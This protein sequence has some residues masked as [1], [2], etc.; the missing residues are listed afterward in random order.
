MRYTKSFL[1]ISAT[2]ESNACLDTQTQLHKMWE[3]IFK[4][5]HKDLW[6]FSTFPPQAKT[7]RRDKKKGSSKW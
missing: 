6:F 1:T 4:K 2:F 7:R 3:I 5:I